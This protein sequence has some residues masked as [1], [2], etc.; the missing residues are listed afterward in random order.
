M[1]HPIDT[2]MDGLDVA[3]TGP[4]DLSVDYGVPGQ[5]DHPDVVARVREVEAAAARTKTMM[6]AFLGSVEQAAKQVAAGY[7]FLA[8]SGDIALLGNAAKALV[9]SLKQTDDPI[10][11]GHQSVLNP[12]EYPM[13]ATGPVAG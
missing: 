4:M 12:D 5:F 9:A 6:G 13:P 3:F 8:V 1:E 11:R 10:T 7:R 2:M